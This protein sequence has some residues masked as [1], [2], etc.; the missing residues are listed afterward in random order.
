VRANWTEAVTWWRKA[1]DAGH[2]ASQHNMG[3]CYALGQGG[4]AKDH[5]LALRWF[6]KA[7]EGRDL[8][9]STFLLNTSAFCKIGSATI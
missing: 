2:A 3:T 7:A 6:A 1:A 8:H 9:S 5:K 4:V